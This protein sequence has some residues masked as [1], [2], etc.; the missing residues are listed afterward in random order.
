MSTLNL[1]SEKPEHAWSARPCKWFMGLE[2][3]LAKSCSPSELKP[4]FLMKL[5]TLGYVLIVH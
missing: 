5:L 1:R 2:I 4:G 3:L